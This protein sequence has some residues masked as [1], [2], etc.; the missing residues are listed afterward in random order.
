[1][2]DGFGFHGFGWLLWLIILGAVIYLVARLLSSRPTRR[3]DAAPPESA[4]EKLKKRYAA[5]EIS[6]KE[7]EQKKKEIES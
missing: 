6:Q 5:G 1:M 3:P 4:L 2:H 7:F